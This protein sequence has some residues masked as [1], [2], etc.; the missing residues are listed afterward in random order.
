[1]HTLV[2]EKESEHVHQ[3]RSKYRIARSFSQWDVETKWQLGQNS[4]GIE[5]FY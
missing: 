5:S 1:M 3:Q 4:S 2:T